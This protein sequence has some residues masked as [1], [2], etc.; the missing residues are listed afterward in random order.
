MKIHERVKAIEELEK[1]ERKFQFTCA[2]LSPTLFGSQIAF[3]DDGDFLTLEQARS[4][5]ALLVEELGG[6]VKW[7]KK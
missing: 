7:G 5:A 4:F 3:T 2:G 1:M 6:T